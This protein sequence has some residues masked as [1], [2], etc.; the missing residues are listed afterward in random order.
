MKFWL[1]VILCSSR[2]DANSIFDNLPPIISDSGHPHTV[3]DKA[4]QFL[5]NPAGRFATDVHYAHVRLPI[6]FQPVLDNMDKII[7][8]MD[9]MANAT[10]SKAT[11]YVTQSV[12]HYTSIQV[13]DMKEDFHNIIDNLPTNGVAEYH[14]KKRFLAEIFGIAGTAFGIANSIAIANINEKL[15]KAIHQTDMLIDITQLH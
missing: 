12:A 13:T 3:P 10:K 1:F 15:A 9:T 14:R 4:N 7:N 11:S 6:H 2:I 5:F 8:A